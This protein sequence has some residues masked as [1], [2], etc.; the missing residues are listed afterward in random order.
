[1]VGRDLLLHRHHAPPRRYSAH[2]HGHGD[3]ESRHRAGGRLHAHDRQHR[4]QDTDER[5]VTASNGANVPTNA[6]RGAPPRNA[7]P[8]PRSAR[9]FTMMELV[10]T[11]SLAAILATIAA[12]S[13]NGMIASQR[14]RT[15]AADLY[16]TLAKARSEAL[17]LNQNATLQ[18]NP[19]E[20]QNGWQ[21]LG[22]HT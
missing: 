13:F 2:L 15:F 10:V 5:L 16:V 18:A 9:G 20:W 6:T 17:T 21:I 19:G 14:A 8:A 1:S 12:P 7:G 11:V 4:R 3:A 22:S